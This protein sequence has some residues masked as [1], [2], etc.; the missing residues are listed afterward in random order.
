MKHVLVTGAA[1]GVGMATCRLLLERGYGVTALVAPW[2]DPDCMRTLTEHGAHVAKGD[3]RDPSTIERYFSGKDAVVHAAALLPTGAAS[4][5]KRAQYETNVKG[6]ENVLRLAH[7]VEVPRAVFLSTAGVASHYEGKTVLGDEMSPYRKPQ[8]AHIWSK[9]E[10]EKILDRISAD[11]RYPIVIL[12]PVTIYGAGM[13]FRW[14]DVFEMVKKGALKLIDDGTAPYPLIHVR[15]LARA[16]L[17][18]VELSELKKTEKII[19]SSDAR[20]TLREITAYISR[21]V[22]AK[23]PGQV[24]YR[25][26]LLASYVLSLIPSFLKPLQLRYLTPPSIRE[27]KYGHLY[28]TEK[29]KQLLRFQAEIPFEAGMREALDE[30]FRKRL[31]S[32]RS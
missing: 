23:E 27:Y 21:Y 20:H 6:S 31:H 29:A 26:A 8:N 12:R 19:I 25:A 32:Q 14:P 10:S 22:G 3:I 11:L 16:V 7:T 17:C 9:I 28:R 13:T 5:T 2:D 30:H 24:P 4:L 18:A 1:G 15:D